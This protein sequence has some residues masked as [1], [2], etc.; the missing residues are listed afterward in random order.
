[1]TDDLYPEQIHNS[2]KS[3]IKKETTKYK[4]WIDKWKGNFVKEE[5]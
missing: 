5:I 2:S 1:M 4:Q 3:M